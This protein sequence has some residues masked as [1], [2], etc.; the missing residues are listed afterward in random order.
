MKSS[1]EKVVV[2]FSGGVDSTTAI[3]I[4]RENG[5]EPVAVYLKMS[6]EKNL[7]PVRHL[8]EKLGVELI[9]KDISEI[10][11]DRIIKGFLSEYQNNK[12]P[13]PCVKC[14]YEI[15]FK[16]LL[17]IADELGV[18]KIATGHYARI[19]KRAGRFHLLK[20]LDGNKDQ[21]YFL[22]RLTQKELARIIFPLGDQK[23][24]VVKKEAL[25]KKWFEKIEESQ[26]VCF[27]EGQKKVQDFLKENLDQ[28]QIE[29]GEIQDEQ[30][31]F[32]GNHQGLVYYTQGQRR[33]LDLPG[34]PYFVVDK[35]FKE[36]ILVVS[37]DNGHP[38]L[39]NSEIYLKQVN[40]IAEEPKPEK[41]YQFKARYRSDF[42][43]GKVEKDQ[44]QWKVVL[45]K[46]QWAVA[47]GQSMV[48]YQEDAVLGG[49]I[50]RKVR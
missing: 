7:E 30:G 47:K 12:T 15:K 26:D 18:N 23:K 32:L 50:I 44:S 3:N 21:S 2:G 19:K 6:K 13:N 28:N 17:K 24:A 35:N 41:I 1:K 40:W 39:I 22:Y 36:N 5:F 45:D 34:G 33:G 27:L 49:G 8:A 25:E 16:I 29:S 10:F 11:K 37:K 48:V 14:N 4:L 38:N 31:S 20:G 9:V 46:P 43:S 42:S